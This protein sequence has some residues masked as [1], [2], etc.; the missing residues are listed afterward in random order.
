M[1]PSRRGLKLDHYPADPSRDPAKPPC[2]PGEQLSA[3]VYYP[4]FVPVQR[5]KSNL[6]I[7]PRS[8]R[9]VGPFHWPS[10]ENSRLAAP[11][12]IRY[13]QQSEAALVAVV[14]RSPPYFHLHGQSAARPGSFVRR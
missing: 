6:R 4:V 11:F 5:K 13:L 12:G 1:S 2:G 10:S 14:L 3:I 7:P 9:A 8:K